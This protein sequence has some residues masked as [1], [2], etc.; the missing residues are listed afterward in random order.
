MA[1]SIESRVPF[2]T[3]A[4]VSFVLA[5]PEEYI[6][7]ADG[8][9]KAVFRKAMR[10][11][12][13]DAVLDRSDKIGFVTPENRWLVALRPWVERRLSSRT[14]LEFAPINARRMS[15]E[16]NDIVAGRRRFDSRVWRWLN[17]ILWVEK[18]AMEVD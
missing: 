16:W 13:P 14:A 5:L 17:T 18:F 15:R 2:L 4:L 12:V 9:T 3:P 6:I 8:T 7:S 10:G 1:S 11:I